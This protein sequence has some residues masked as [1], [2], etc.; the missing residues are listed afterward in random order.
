M[1][2]LYVGKFRKK[3]ATEFL[4]A[5]AFTANGHEIM[6][7]D[8]GSKNA[9]SRISEA[10]GFDL[11]VFSKCS[12]IDP[13]AIK[14]LRCPKAMWLFDG[15][16]YSDP[17]IIREDGSSI[18][19]R[20]S[21]MDVVFTSSYCDVEFYRELG[22]ESEWLPQAVEVTEPPDP[23][24][25]KMIRTVFIGNSYAGRRAAIISELHGLGVN[26]VVYGGNWPIDMLSGGV[27][28]GVSMNR[29]NDVYRASM[30]A[31]GIMEMEGDK[32]SR[33]VWQITGLGCPMI[34]EAIPSLD[35]VFE[36][37]VHYLGWRNPLECAEMVE[38]VLEDPEKSASMAQAAYDE[39]IA[40]HTYGHRVRQLV[41]RMKS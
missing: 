19:E 10:T 33:R 41:E 24:A 12:N 31:L 34:H 4:V 35:L 14:A 27:F 1:R 25:I 6:N 32:F 8:S 2:V 38:S 16:F 18:I 15:L 37:G 22:I 29:I 11:A 23:R 13:S 26:V 36:N 17:R 30:C 28:G 40:N 20:A 3:T 39:V 7:I 9:N 21:V 5:A